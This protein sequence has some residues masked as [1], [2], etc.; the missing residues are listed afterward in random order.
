MLAA[1]DWLAYE[2]CHKDEAEAWFASIAGRIATSRPRS[3]DWT[4][5]TPGRRQHC[6]QRNSENCSQTVANKTD[7]GGFRGHA[8][9]NRWCRKCRLHTSLD[10]SGCQRTNGRKILRSHRLQVRILP[11]V[12]N[13]V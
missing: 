2:A 13:Q 7:I 4:Y 10:T 5:S 11:G 6:E 9:T 1:V 3:T 8:W 12:L